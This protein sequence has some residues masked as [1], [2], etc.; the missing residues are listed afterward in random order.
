MSVLHLRFVA[1]AFVLALMVGLP[2]NETNAEPV[3]VEKQA[4]S[5]FE[6]VSAAIRDGLKAKKMAIV[7][8]IH[9]HD[10]LEVVGVSSELATTYETFHPRYGKVLYA[11]DKAAFIEVPLR[12]HVRE[13]DNGVV[14][15]Y[16]T[17]S[18][19]F[20]AYNG[21]AKMGAE[22]DGLFADVVGGA[23]K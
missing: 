15:Q 4:K 14:V 22:L 9:F 5:E 20:A 8:Q 11:N 18:S 19:I 21:L 23:I 6:A 10:M 3:L 7:R 17:P 13:T 1:L 2:I 16:R 12:I